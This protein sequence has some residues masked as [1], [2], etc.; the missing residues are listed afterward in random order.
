ML[1]VVD[2]REFY[3]SPLGQMTRRMLSHRIRSRFR[4]GQGARVLG[5][6]YAI[7]YL[8][9]WRA[10][11]ERVFAFMPARQGVVHWPQSGLNAAALVEEAT[12]RC[13]MPRSIWRWWCMGSSSPT[14]SPISC[15][16]CGGCWRRR[17][18]RCSSCP[19]GAACGHGSN[20]TP[21]GHGRP[22]S[23]SQLTDLLRDAAFSP[24][25][26]AYALFAPPI[27]RS[28][29]IRS[30]PAFERV[31]LWISPGFAGLI[32]VEAVKQVY[33]ISR[34]KR[35]KRLMPVIKPRL[36]PVPSLRRSRQQQ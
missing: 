24:T 21:F 26:W 18:G 25:G 14:S 23:R 11:A 8:E 32:V 28:F 31:G 3:A 27:G 17:A 7:P 1:D 10:E 13:P 4:P 22:F 36:I 33:A 5:I 12:C 2:L 19:T 15:A 16:S 29:L 20:S 9:P 30:A 34:G 35:A 6:G